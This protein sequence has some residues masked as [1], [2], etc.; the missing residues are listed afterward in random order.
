M[1]DRH[2]IAGN[3]AGRAAPELLARDGGGLMVPQWAID[4]GF[5]TDKWESFD[6]DAPGRF[7]L[8]AQGFRRC[9]ECGFWVRADATSPWVE[10]VGCAAEEAER[11]RLVQADPD[12]HCVRCEVLLSGDERT[13][14]PD[15]DGGFWCYPCTAQDHYD[16]CVWPDYQ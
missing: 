15:D 13:D 14:E 6:W 8:L 9:A 16:Q 3:S 10:C 5:P 2:D 4:A 1:T 12:G 7:A 11:V